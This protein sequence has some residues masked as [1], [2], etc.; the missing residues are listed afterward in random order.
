MKKYYITA[1]YMGSGSS[2]LTDLLSEFEGVSSPNGDFEYVFLHAPN[3]LFDLED[4]L[5]IGNNALR[6]DEAI[7]SFLKLMDDL[8]RKKRYWVADYKHK[9]SEDFPEYVEQ[10]IRD[11]DPTRPDEDTYWYYMQD[12]TGYMT[13]L[14]MLRKALYLLSFKRILVPQPLRYRGMTLAFPS[15]EEFYE[16]ARRFVYAVME[17]VRAD[18]EAAIFDQMLLPHNLFRADRYFRD[19]T[20]IV[21]ADR[22]PRDVFLAN[23]YYWKPQHVPLP[24]PTEVEDFCRVYRKMRENVRKAD[25][26][27]IVKVQF[28]DLIYRYD[29]T[30][31]DLYR[32]LQLPKQAHTAKRQHFDPS[33]SIVN[34]NI[35]RKDQRYRREAEIIEK[36][37]GEYL[38]AFPEKYDYSAERNDVF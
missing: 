7:H 31:E 2:A 3:G 37:L 28:E 12:P 1:G 25:S 32:E 11:L 8:Y 26:K 18:H 19:D 16:A 33:V 13:F 6:S 35:Q 29:E 4:K 21:L 36:R 23:K 24:F 30:L 27:L 34:T 20:A 10:L 14:R 15:D 17:A 9:V 22:D 38:Y 5:L